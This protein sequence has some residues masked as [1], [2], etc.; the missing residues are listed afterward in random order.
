MIIV[1]DGAPNAKGPNDGKTNQQL[2]DEAVAFAD[3][4]AASGVSIFTIFYDQNNDD[5]AAAFFESLVRGDG[6][7]LRTPDPAQLPE[8]FEAV[9]AERH[10]ILVQ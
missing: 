7:A 6:E 9:C 8:L 3:Q 1:G 10:A 5:T 2:K 4:A